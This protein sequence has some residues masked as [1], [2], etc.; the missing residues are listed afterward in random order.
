[1]IHP[2]SLFQ[3]T[4]TRTAVAHVLDEEGLWSEL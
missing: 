3:L 4:H 1:M 2:I